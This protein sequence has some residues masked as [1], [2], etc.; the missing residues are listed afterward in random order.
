MEHEDDNVIN[1][2]LCPW[3][4]SQRHGKKT[5]G[6]RD[7][8]KNRYHPDH[9]TVEISLCTEETPEYLKKL[10]ATE[11]VEKNHALKVM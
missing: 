10:A 5:G 1:L 2:N 6:T 11:T 3:G 4:G 8:R 9:S 7:Q